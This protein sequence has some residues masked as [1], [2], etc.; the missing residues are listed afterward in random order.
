MNMNVSTTP[1]HTTD[2]KNA[3]GT[4]LP[5]VVVMDGSRISGEASGICVGT[6]PNIDNIFKET[7]NTGTDRVLT[8]LL[9]P[10]SREGRNCWRHRDVMMLI[11]TFKE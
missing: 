2:S 4:E 5:L 1:R 9:G 10:E 11:E 3:A 8:I 6:C 7:Q